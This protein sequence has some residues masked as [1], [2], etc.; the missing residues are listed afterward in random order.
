MSSP[1]LLTH[2]T[3]PLRFLFDPVS[4][5]TFWADS[6]FLSS[7]TSVL[8]WRSGLRVRRDDSPF[9]FS[10]R[11]FLSTDKPSCDGRWADWPPPAR[12][13]RCSLTDFEGVRPHSFLGFSVDSF[14]SP[15][16]SKAI[17]VRLLLGSPSLFLFLCHRRN[18]E[19]REPSPL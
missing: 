12:S 4:S 9:F 17:K 15:L 2:H 6:L 16:F 5:M 14:F 10:T 7:S 18:E 11:Y 1:S 19:E 3:F 8:R 13:L